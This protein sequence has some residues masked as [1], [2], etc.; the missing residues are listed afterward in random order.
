[1]FEVYWSEPAVLRLRHLHEQV[2][3][4]D[5]I[6]AAM[7]ELGE[8]LSAENIGAGA[9]MALGVALLLRERHSQ[10]PTG[11]QASDSPGH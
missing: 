10:A 6:T 7:R 3:D 5:A 9:L 2:N 11:P 4:P 1:M 8:R